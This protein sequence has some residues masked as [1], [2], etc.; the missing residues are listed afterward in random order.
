M[1]AGAD[2]TDEGAS[3]VY[4]VRPEAAR[5]DELVRRP[6]PTGNESQIHP[7]GAIRRWIGPQRARFL[8]K[9]ALIAAFG[10]IVLAA[11]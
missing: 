4:G 6:D 5:F 2:N 11:A 10:L 3:F 9:A 7:P 1:P 8:F